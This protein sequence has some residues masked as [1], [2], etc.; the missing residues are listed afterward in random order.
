MIIL[1]QH[2]ILR[3]AQDERQRIVYSAQ[4]TDVLRLL[5]SA[6]CCFIAKTLYGE[7]A[8]AICEEITSQ[9]RLTCTACIRRVVARIEVSINEVWSQ[10]AGLHLRL[11][12]IANWPFL[13]YILLLSEILHQAKIQY[14]ELLNFLN[15][16]ALFTMFFLHPYDFFLKCYP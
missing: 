16:R 11:K 4:V 2:G 5:R 14:S 8:E 12:Y 7:I 6:R 13:E 1:E 3:F 15:V 9:G 10:L